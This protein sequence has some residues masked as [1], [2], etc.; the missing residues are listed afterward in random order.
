MAFYNTF[1]LS[2]SQNKIKISVPFHAGKGGV[3]IGSNW[4]EFKAKKCHLPDFWGPGDTTT[5][6]E[7]YYYLA[8]LGD[9]AQ[10]VPPLDKGGTTA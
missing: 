4:F 9:R 6:I 10:A 7:W 1:E 8:L 3:Y 5:I 2:N